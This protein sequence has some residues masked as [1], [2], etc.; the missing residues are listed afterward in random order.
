[1]KVNGPKNKVN[2]YADL[3]DEFGARCSYISL[4]SHHIAILVGA[5]WWDERY[6]LD[7]ISN[8]N[9]MLSAAQSRV[10]EHFCYYLQYMMQSVVVS[11]WLTTYISP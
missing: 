1:M 8:S 11:E 4:F 6:L 10:R 7:L 5:A 3:S 2:G 9:E